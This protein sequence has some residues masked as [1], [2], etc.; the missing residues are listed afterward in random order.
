MLPFTYKYLRDTQQTLHGFIEKHRV[1]IGFRKCWLMPNVSSDVLEK[2]Y[3]KKKIYI[4]IYR[5]FH[6]LL[7]HK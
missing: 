2:K 1:G 3:L 7:S 5:I 6:E 4:S